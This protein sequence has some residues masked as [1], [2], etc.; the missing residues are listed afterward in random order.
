MLTLYEE[1]MCLGRSRKVL[2]ADAPVL[3][4]IIGNEKL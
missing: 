1:Q 2:V 4:H 3:R